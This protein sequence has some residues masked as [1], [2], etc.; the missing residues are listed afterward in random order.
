MQVSIFTT[1]K[2]KSFVIIVIVHVL[3]LRLCAFDSQSLPSF[4]L[5]RDVDKFVEYLQQ[6]LDFFG[7]M[8]D[9]DEIPGD[10]DDFVPF[11]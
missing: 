9:G 5:Y 4:F 7:K 11:I 2:S 10:N 6:T 3:R 8:G 1:P